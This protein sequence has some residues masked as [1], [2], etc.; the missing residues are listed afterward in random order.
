M[1]RIIGPG[2][3]SGKEKRYGSIQQKFDKKPNFKEIKTSLLIY[4]KLVFNILGFSRP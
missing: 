4:K 1:G 3:D 2:I